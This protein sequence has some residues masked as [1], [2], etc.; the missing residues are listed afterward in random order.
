MAQ[1]Q[2]GYWL[3]CVAAWIGNHPRSEALRLLSSRLSHFEL[4]SNAEP[5]LGADADIARAAVSVV[6]RGVPSSAPAFLEDAFYAAGLDLSSGARINSLFASL[7]PVDPRIKKEFFLTEYNS[8]WGTAR[9][10]ALGSFYYSVMPAYLGGFILQVAERGKSVSDFLR[11][12]A[13]APAQGNDLLQGAKLDFF[14]EFPYPCKNCN[15]AVVQIGDGSHDVI[16]SERVDHALDQLVAQLQLAPT[17][18]FT[19]SEL[20]DVKA[21]IRPLQECLNNDYLNQL[22]AN[23]YDALYKTTDGLDALQLALSPF[24]IARVQRAVLEALAQGYLSLSDDRWRIAVVERDVPAA[25]LA[26]DDLKQV[27][28]NLLKI[29][30]DETILPS[31]DLTIYTSPEFSA[32]KLNAYWRDRSSIQN[33][34]ILDISQLPQRADFQLLVDLS[35]LQSEAV[36]NGLSGS[37]LARVCFVVRSSSSIRSYRSHAAGSPI[38]F[39]ALLPGQAGIDGAAYFSNRMLGFKALKDL[40]IRQFNLMAASESAV[41]IAPPASGKTFVWQLFAM[42]QPGFSLCLVPTLSLGQELAVRL[43]AWGNDNVLVLDQEAVCPSQLERIKS[44]GFALLIATADGYCQMAVK[45]ALAEAAARGCV[46][47]A[48]FVEESQ[49]FSV[50]SSDFRPSYSAAVAFC[51]AVFQTPKRKLPVYCFATSASYD[52]LADIQA[53]ASALPS[54][55]IVDARMAKNVS[56]NVSDIRL[57]NLFYNTDSE[58]A[59]AAV[60]NRK[61]VAVS[62]IVN[63]NLNKTENAAPYRTLLVTPKAKGPW[64]VIDTDKNGLSDKLLVSFPDLRSGYNL[65]NNDNSYSSYS[66]ALKPK[67]V[68][69]SKANT[70]MFRFGKLDLLASVSSYSCSLYRD[71]VEVVIANSIPSSPDALLQ[72][73]YKAGRNG[74]AARFVLLYGGQLIQVDEEID[75]GRATSSR[76]ID[77]TPDVLLQKEKLNQMY[78]GRRREMNIVTEFLTQF[79]YGNPQPIDAILDKAEDLFGFVP[80][81]QL[82]KDGGVEFLKLY[83]GDVYYG[84]INLEFL[85]VAKTDQAVDK[86]VSEPLIALFIKEI[87][88]NCPSDIKHAAWLFADGALPPSDGILKLLDGLAEGQEA[89]LEINFENDSIYQISVLLGQFAP[90]VFS[91][92]VVRRLALSTTDSSKFIAELNKIKAIDSLQLG[93][94]ERVRSLFFSIRTGND[95]FKMIGRL[96]ELGVVSGFSVDS[97]KRKLSLKLTKRTSEYYIQQWAAYLDRHFVSGVCT[98]LIA[99]LDRTQLLRSILEQM[100]DFAYTEVYSKSM[101]AIATVNNLLA[102]QVLQ[103][104][105]SNECTDSMLDFFKKVNV[106]RYALPYVQGNL[107]SDLLANPK[108]SFDTALRLQADCRGSKDNLWHLLMS[109]EMLLKDNPNHFSLLIINGF[110]GMLLQSDDHIAVD[111]YLNVLADGFAKMFSVEKLR[112][113]EYLTRMSLFVN[114]MF[115]YDRS[116]K[117]RVE[118][119]MLYK[120]HLAWLKGFNKHFALSEAY[121]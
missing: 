60:A 24:A 9:E 21:P 114:K 43:A 40:Q 16:S 96:L 23:Y 120:H 25:I 57:N 10:E 7:H 65:S 27:L 38:G 48:L 32:S 64:G 97:S 100:V 49:C 14:F 91:S 66:E 86:L 59:S 5:A 36:A 69:E 72:L 67:L 107:V 53:A 73:A 121:G 52:V 103:Q 28:V 99:A 110:A 13:D 116:L 19:Y 92:S 58:T 81:Y 47:T 70:N 41:F 46:P 98:R 102:A 2:A 68:A 4:T 45:S 111:R 80:E 101:A 12:W 84:T 76:K 44:G 20:A 104:G 71:D 33:V 15:G 30:G 39:D 118:P 8:K 56:F 1:L 82:L 85:T 29:K 54:Q 88:N 51:R 77:I 90:G 113:T 108:P 95:T 87:S 106:A 37:G 42:L 105:K 55:V 34:T 78:P 109:T 3:K 112:Q 117:A 22:S 17:F 79:T 83:K 18:R 61:Q 94:S 11:Y 115:E 31:I 119:V 74:A 63:D 50:W 93:L 26:M 89:G 6:S 35:I 75:N 62:M